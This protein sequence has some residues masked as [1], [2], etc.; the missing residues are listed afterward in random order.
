MFIRWKN[1]VLVELDKGGVSE[2]MRQEIEPWE[3]L[4][5]LKQKAEAPCARHPEG[6]CDCAQREKDRREKGRKKRRDRS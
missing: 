6:G 3:E 4:E 1:S 5:T 2:F